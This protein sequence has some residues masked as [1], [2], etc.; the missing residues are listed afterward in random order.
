MPWPIPC[1]NFAFWVH[2]VMLATDYPRQDGVFPYAP[3]FLRGRLK[4]I[5]KESTQQVMAGGALGFY[6]VT[7]RETRF[8][9]LLES[10][11]KC[12]SLNLRGHRVLTGLIYML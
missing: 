4:S 7:G 12:N 8:E 5:S 1:R 10:H 3:A 6:G 11:A 2:R 9:K